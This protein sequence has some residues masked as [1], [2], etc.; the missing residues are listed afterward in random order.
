[1]IMSRY[2]VL[3]IDT[4]EIVETHENF[5]EARDDAVQY[6]RT[7]AEVAYTVVEF[8][9]TYMHVKDDKGITYV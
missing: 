1:M 7:N 4:N 2:Y 9:N 5:K 8:I 6:A 3:C